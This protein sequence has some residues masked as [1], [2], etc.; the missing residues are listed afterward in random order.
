MSFK[1]ITIKAYTRNPPSKVSHEEYIS[2][3]NCSNWFTAQK[4]MNSNFNIL[5]FCWHTVGSIFH[6]TL[7]LTPLYKRSID[8][9][10]YFFYRKK[11]DV[12][13]MSKFNSLDW[14]RIVMLK[15]LNLLRIQNPD[16]PFIMDWSP[17]KILWISDFFYNFFMN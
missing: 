5:R 14:G 17:G 9:I 10:K 6:P 4:C 2:N 15:I 8:I 16:P 3:C 12:L 1:K 11:W 13:L 7:V